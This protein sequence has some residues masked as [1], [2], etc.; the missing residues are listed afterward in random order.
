M[1]WRNH[2]RWLKFAGMAALTG[3]VAT[4]ALVARTERRRRA[5]TPDE[6]RARLHERL[7]DA[8]HGGQQGE[9]TVSSD[10]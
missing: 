6:V 7:T 4:G 8:E 2:N 5:Y 10:R 3:V 1:A 9:T